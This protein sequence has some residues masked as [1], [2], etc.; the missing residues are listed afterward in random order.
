MPILLVT[1]EEMIYLSLN[2]VKELATMGTTQSNVDPKVRIPTSHFTH[3]GKKEQ[4]V[5][6]SSRYPRG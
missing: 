5:K 4:D 1:K 6:H 3:K 2:G